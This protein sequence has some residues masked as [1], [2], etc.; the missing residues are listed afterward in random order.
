[1]EIRISGALTIEKGLEIIRKCKELYNEKVILNLSELQFVDTKASNILLLLPFFLKNNGNTV[2]IIICRHPK[3]YHWLEIIGILN[4]FSNNFDIIGEKFKTQSIYH[5]KSALMLRTFFLQNEYDYKILSAISQY[6]ENIFPEKNIIS[7]RISTCIVE[8]INNIFDHSEEKF[9]AISILP[10]NGHLHIAVTDFGIGI[11][12][13]LLKSEI[14][15]PYANESD[16]Y[17][18]KKAI[19]LNVS[20]TNLLNR[21]FGLHLVTKYAD[22]TYIASGNSVVKLYNDGTKKNNAKLVDYFNGTNINCILS[23][24]MEK[25]VEGIVLETLKS[26]KQQNLYRKNSR[27][28]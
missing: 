4:N 17:F 11:K 12:N 5:L 20:S 7:N 1:M 2:S 24:E 15:S 19:N 21:G 25:L 3:V 22:R 6:C 28:L 9:G 13:S 14:F 23:L 8:L 26:Q 27:N 16:E 18:I 10:V